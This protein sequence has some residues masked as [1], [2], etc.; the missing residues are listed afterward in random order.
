MDI[1]Y[2]SIQKENYAPHKNTIGQ[3]KAGLWGN[4]L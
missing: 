3:G 4:E 1:Y 2:E